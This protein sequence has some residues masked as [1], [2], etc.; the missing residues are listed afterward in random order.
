M[1]QLVDRWPFWLLAG[2]LLVSMIGIG[3]YSANASNAIH[4]VAFWLVAALVLKAAYPRQLPNGPVL[5]FVRRNDLSYGLYLVHMPVI[6][7]L[8]YR[9]VSH[10]GMD[11]FVL[12]V[13]S[14]AWA[15]LS[16][17]AIERPALRRKT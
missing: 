8:L 6:N 9:G 15:L 3:D 2:L 5:D 14:A 7:L 11:L 12:V 10:P 4:P 16:W 1:R 13:V 17:F